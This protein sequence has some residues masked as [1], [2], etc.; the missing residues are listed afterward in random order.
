[1]LAIYG[2]CTLT[3]IAL[4]TLVIAHMLGKYLFG[5]L[6]LNGVG[7]HH[8]LCIRRL[9]DLAHLQGAE[10]IGEDFDRQLQFDRWRSRALPSKDAEVGEVKAPRTSYWKAAL[11][12]CL[13]L[14]A[15]FPYHYEP[16][17]QFVVFPVLKEDLTTD[18]PGVIEEVLF[19]GGEFAQEGHGTGAPRP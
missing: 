18:T 17:G 16:A 12:I 5:N 7:H 4:V 10:E 1:M 11:V 2:L 14:L 6:H 15:F 13:V 19:D 8:H 9:D 3:W